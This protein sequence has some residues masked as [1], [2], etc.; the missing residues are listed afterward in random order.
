M[1][2]KGI[3]KL[4]DSEKSK[5]FAIPSL[6]HG[7]FLFLGTGGSTGI[8]VIG[9]SCAVCSSPVQ[10]NRRLRPSGVIKIAGKTLLVDVSPDFREQ[11]LTHQLLHLDGIL[12]TH[13]HFDHIGGLE[14]LRPYFFKG[15]EP[16]PCLLSQDTYKQL[17]QRCPYIVLAEKESRGVKFAFQIF[18]KDFGPIEF[19]NFPFIVVS[20]FQSQMKVTGYRL[21]PFAY[22]CDIRD[23][24]ERVMETLEGVETLVL[25]TLAEHPTRAHLGVEEAVAFAKRVGAKK[26]YLTHLAHAIEH[27]EMTKRLPPDIYL[28]YDGLTIHF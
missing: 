24:E 12:I 27:E 6:I 20:Y 17:A 25:D 22:I 15:R 16:L 1:S 8:P 5:S 11:A 2:L 26:T 21:G 23:F 13:A 14:D 4:H 10:K 3:A 28:S 18:E 19:L 7:Q 9:C